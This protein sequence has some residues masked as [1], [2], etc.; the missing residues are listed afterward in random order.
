[1]WIKT[2]LYSLPVIAILGL[3]FYIKNTQDR[4]LALAEKTTLLEAYNEEL[5]DEL[6]NIQDNIIALED[7]NIKTVEAANEARNALKAFEDSNLN[8]LSNSKP[9]LIENIINRG[10]NNLFKDFENESR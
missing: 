3:A 7:L 6:I 1:M 9:V 10:T 8:S 4:L 5:R 2:L